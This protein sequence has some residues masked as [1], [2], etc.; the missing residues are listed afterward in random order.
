MATTEPSGS[1]VDEFAA[2]GPREQAVVTTDG[3][4]N[5]LDVVPD[6]IL[7]TDAVVVAT[8]C[9]PRDVE[10]RVTRHDGNAERVRV[11][12]VG[13]PSLRYDGPLTV[14]ER[15]GP[16]DLTGIGV[17]FTEFV[18]SLD[19]EDPW[20]VVDNLNVFMMYAEADRVCRFLDTVMGKSRT[21][22]ARGI[23]FAVREAV[24]D[25]TYGELT[26]PCD[27]ELDVR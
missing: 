18:R 21:H 24:T 8:S 3:T 2:L 9:H 16:N 1:E 17:R 14:A 23:Y 5:C 11:I 4:S 22:G 26:K 25:D 10:E 12:P 27:R 15:T 13:G 6:R 7:D 20:V 19:S